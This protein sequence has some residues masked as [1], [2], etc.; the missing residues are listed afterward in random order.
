VGLDCAQGEESEVL[1]RLQERPADE[2]FVFDWLI[3]SNTARAMAALEAD[4][5]LQVLSLSLSHIN[6]LSRTR[7]FRRILVYP[8]LCTNAFCQAAR[9][10]LVPGML[11]EDVFWRNYFYKCDL[12]ISSFLK[13]SGTGAASTNTPKPS[14]V[15]DPV[16]APAATASAATAAVG[17]HSRQEQSTTGESDS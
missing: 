17:P 13:M 8:I 16:A 6:H 10:K 11:K 7:G 4:P 1:R 9:L 12:I 14:A 15:V 5:G 2:D 3:P